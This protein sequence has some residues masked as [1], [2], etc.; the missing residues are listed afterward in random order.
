MSRI[1]DNFKEFISLRTQLIHINIPAWNKTSRY[2]RKPRQR[3]S[4]EKTLIKTK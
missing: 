3:R 1:N 4:N 2:D